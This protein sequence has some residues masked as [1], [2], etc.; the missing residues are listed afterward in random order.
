MLLMG[1]PTISPAKLGKSP[2]MVLLAV[3]ALCL[4]AVRGHKFRTLHQLY[5]PV[6]GHSV[7]NLNLNANEA[8]A[9][10]L[11]T[12]SIENVGRSDPE[13]DVPE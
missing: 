2:G 1:R 8:S 13:L 11:I 4:T 6:N 3:L 10:E 12:V 9:N 5:I 7:L